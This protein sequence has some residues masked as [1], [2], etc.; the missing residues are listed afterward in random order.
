MPQSNKPE[1]IGEA[2][3]Q[4]RVMI[5]E[6]SKENIL[7]KARARIED[8]LPCDTLLL[9]P[10]D[11]GTLRDTIDTV[12]GDCITLAGPGAVTVNVYPESCVKSGGFYWRGSLGLFWK[13]RLDTDPYKNATGLKSVPTSRRTYPMPNGLF[14]AS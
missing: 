3:Q 8:G 12:K 6:P 5:F 9:S 2:I 14:T 10:T 13:W 4:L 11:W 7:E 1:T